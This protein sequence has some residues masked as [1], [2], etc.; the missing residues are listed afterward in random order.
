MRAV[1]ESH[2]DLESIPL[3][4]VGF[5]AAPEIWSRKRWCPRCKAYTTQSRDV[6]KWRVSGRLK[7]IGSLVTILESPFRT[8]F[9]EECRRRLRPLRRNWFYRHVAYE[10]GP[11][12]SDEDEDEKE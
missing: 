6:E 8:W 9:C 4:P 11:D 7:G 1:R 12:E 3:D 5:M 2:Y 10:A